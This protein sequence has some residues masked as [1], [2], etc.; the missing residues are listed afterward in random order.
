MV[1]PRRPDPRPCLARRCGPARPGPPGAGGDADREPEPQREGRHHG[2]RTPGRRRGSTGSAG[3]GKVVEQGDEFVAVARRIG[4]GRRTSVS[5]RSRRP[6]GAQAAEPRPRPRVQ[7]RW[8][9]LP[10]VRGH[11]CLLSPAR[12]CGRTSDAIGIECLR[13][14]QR[15]GDTLLGPREVPEKGPRR[16]HPTDRIVLTSRASRLSL[17]YLFPAA[18]SRMGGRAVREV[19]K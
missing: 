3:V 17:R 4:R 7:H 11:A 10:R 9:P 6:S 14:G 12:R 2:N 18:S 15:D 1:R 13:V 5:S 19:A 16:P 8:P